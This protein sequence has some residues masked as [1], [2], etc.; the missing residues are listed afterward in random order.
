MIT[1]KDMQE[2]AEEF[3]GD[4]LSPE[5]L[6]SGVNHL[7]RCPCGE[8]FLATRDR[9]LQLER[10]KDGFCPK[11]RFEQGGKKHQ[12]YNIEDMHRVAKERNGKFLSP[13]YRN[14]RTLHRWYCNI[15]KYEWSAIP[16]TVLSR[17]TP[18]WC[19][20]CGQ[21]KSSMAKRTPIEK[22]R[23]H[24][25]SRGGVLLSKV[26]DESVLEIV[27]QHGH[28]W[29]T[30][31]KYLRQG[32]WCPRCAVR[33]VGEA[34]C[35]T[36][37]EQI[38]SEKF[39]TL[40]PVW[41]VNDDGNQ[42]HLDGY[43]PS[44]GIAFEHHGDQHFTHH[45]F[46][47]AS[48]EDLRKRMADDEKK[49]QLCKQYEVILFEIPQ[50]PDK[51][52]IKELPRLIKRL[53][54]KNGTHFPLQD[55][56]NFIPDLSDAFT[57]KSIQRLFALKEKAKELGGVCLADEYINSDEPL[58]FVCAVGHPWKARPRHIMAN[59]WCEKCR[60]KEAWKKRKRPTYD[61]IKQFADKK[62]FDCPFQEVPKSHSKMLFICRA[63]RHD[64]WCSLDNF[65]SKKH[66]G[67][68]WKEQ[69]PE[70]A[71]EMR[72]KKEAREKS[73]ERRR[74]E[75]RTDFVRYVEAESYKCLSDYQGVKT[76]VLLLCPA[77]HLWKCTPDNFKNGGRRC[78]YCRRS[79]RK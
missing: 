50:V 23:K 19:P 74:E 58:P 13:V 32:K 36:I 44:L 52:A 57:S 67:V 43:S 77:G 79:S 26:H 3:G 49:R 41:L 60:K 54:H 75:N 25:E 8:P 51:V 76:S 20:K 63:K 7:W 1:V 9:I 37:F 56:E 78:K 29:K 47:H 6:G 53:C 28:E 39:E 21:K 14:T 69:L 40:Q 15:H 22:I 66:C 10:N 55:I 24:V 70:R 35:R 16:E 31:W 33:S 48:K 4:F 27:C 5:Y 30:D 18:T 73:R 61:E 45:K 38:F 17:K 46:F 42:M 2:L 34:I 11:C 65:R 64:W 62:G 12:K 72:G 59:H 71:A 68:C